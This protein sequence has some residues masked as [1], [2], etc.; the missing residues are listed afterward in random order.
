MTITTRFMTAE[1][2]E[3][4]PNRDGLWEV[5]D[6]ELVEVTGTGGEHAVVTFAIML[7]LGNFVTPRRLGTI[8]LPDSSIV[9]AE[10]PLVLRSPDT[11][12]IRADRLPLD[13]IP[14]GYIR[15]VPNL[16]VDVRSPGDSRPAM[17]AKGK[18]WLEAGATLVWLID[19][20]TE[21]ATVLDRSGEPREFTPDDT[22][23]GGDVLPGFQL[24]VR[25]IFAI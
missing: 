8:L 3:R 1:E 13:Q 20:I 10:N 11:G 6:G 16:I 2:L 12:F 4:S 18:M 15:V 5:I 22:L 14:R 23:D 7:R 25:D 19:P 21:L 24:P 9:L 17:M